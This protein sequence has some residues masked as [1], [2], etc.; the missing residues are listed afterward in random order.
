MPKL[1]MKKRRRR[2]PEPRASPSS[3]VALSTQL[4]QSKSEARYGVWDA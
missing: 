1:S 2:M 4:A 3:T